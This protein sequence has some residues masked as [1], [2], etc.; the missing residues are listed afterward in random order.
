MNAPSRQNQNPLRTIPE[1]EI[2]QR[3][4]RA[5]REEPLRTYIP[6]TGSMPL[7]RRWTEET[8]TT[9]SGNIFRRECGLLSCTY[10]NGAGES[11]WAAASWAWEPWGG[12]QAE[13]NNTR[14]NIP[15]GR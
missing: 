7:G 1:G 13:G 8:L 14:T 3:T 9:T 2:A 5:M 4:I 6:G 10:Y 12:N 15:R 11:K